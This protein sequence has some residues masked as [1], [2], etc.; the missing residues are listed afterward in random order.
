MTR[1]VLKQ[2]ILVKGWDWDG[3]MDRCLDYHWEIGS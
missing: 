1:P 2:Y 3:H